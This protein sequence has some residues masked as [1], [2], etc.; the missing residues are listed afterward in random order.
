MS[1]EQDG[2][3][4]SVD[5][6]VD[7]NMNVGHKIVLGLLIILSGGVTFAMVVLL[8]NPH[9]SNPFSDLFIIP[10]K[11]IAQ[12]SQPILWLMSVIL[13]KLTYQNV[14]G[15]SQYS[16]V[17]ANI[18]IV[19]SSMYSFLL[20]FFMMR[21][22]YK[23]Q[24]K[25]IQTNGYLHG[26]RIIKISFFIGWVLIIPFFI[27]QDTL[28][29]ED[30]QKSIF[31]VCKKGAIGKD[32]YRKCIRRYIYSKGGNCLEKKAVNLFP[33][34]QPDVNL[35]KCTLE[36]IAKKGSFKNITIGSRVLIDVFYDELLHSDKVLQEKFC[37]SLSAKIDY[38]DAD[39]LSP[40]EYC[41]LIFKLP[42]SE[43]A[44]CV[45][46]LHKEYQ[47]VSDYCDNPF[48][49]FKSQGNTCYQ[50]YSQERNKK[51]IPSEK[52]KKLFVHFKTAFIPRNIFE[53]FFG[54]NNFEISSQYYDF[55]YR[56]KESDY[57]KLY[58]TILANNLDGTTSIEILFG[59]PEGGDN[60]WQYNRFNSEI[61]TGEKKSTKIK[62]K[63]VDVYYTL[64]IERNSSSKKAFHFVVGQTYVQI[65][66]QEATDSGNG[67]KVIVDKMIPN[68][69]KQIK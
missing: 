36:N 17:L 65:D 16:Y 40:L 15:R 58:Y 6:N 31:Y 50:E 11:V 35:D 38:R 7:K 63:G 59:G 48:K 14:Y 12:L 66:F 56:Y 18:V 49:P 22:V 1:R 68:I 46:E 8:D 67:Y 13:D 52:C 26:V 4:L 42:L 53:E 33:L 62:I 34:K 44:Y 28:L 20:G 55:A 21:F 37:D 27:L 64:P 57:P 2:A 30:F 51:L 61:K 43:Q 60:Y 19:L 29:K 39:H 41:K 32:V 54:S 9:L 10:L 45:A 25:I 47:Q 69:I 3:N 5:E 23:S 24:K